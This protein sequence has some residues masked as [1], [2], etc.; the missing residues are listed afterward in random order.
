MSSGY[1]SVQVPIRDQ[2]DLIELAAALQLKQEELTET[3]PFDAETTVQILVPATTAAVAIARKWL[4]TRIQA[5]KSYRVFVDGIE[6]TGY[7]APE[8]NRLIEAIEKA[9]RDGQS[10]L[11]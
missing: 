10:E 7:S 8:A 2:E 1:I 6:F 9:R 4:E 3:H 11:Q 5:R